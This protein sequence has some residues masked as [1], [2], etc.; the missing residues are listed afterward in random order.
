MMT[1][2]TT[3]MI[4]RR[5]RAHRLRGQTWVGVR[6]T[7]AATAARTFSSNQA[8]ITTLI[9]AASAATTAVPV[10]VVLVPAGAAVITAATAVWEAAVVVAAAAVAAVV[11]ECQSAT[12]SVGVGAEGCLGA[13]FSFPEVLLE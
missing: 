13:I 7:Q 12:M 8:A 10:P 3:T 4:G 5:G 11:D 6:L 2:T 9:Q 1:M